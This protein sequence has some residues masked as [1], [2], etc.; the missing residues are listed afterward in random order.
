[1]EA[2]AEEEPEGAGKA[3]GAAGVEG[4]VGAEAGPAPPG[5][6]RGGAEEER[7]EAPVDDGDVGEEGGES[8]DGGEE[9]VAGGGAVE[10]G[11][12]VEGGEVADE[13]VAPAEEDLGGAELFEV[14]GD[15]A[16]DL[17]GGDVCV[18]VERAEAGDGR[19]SRGTGQ[20][21]RAVRLECGED[22]EAE[23]A[24]I[25]VLDGDGQFDVLDAEIDVGEIEGANEEFAAIG[26]FEFIF[27]GCPNVARAA[28]NNSKNVLILMVEI[29]RCRVA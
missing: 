8:G 19:G 14:W 2:D 17:A 18:R 12:D 26:D 13:P 9:A 25:R 16:E 4:G 10:D 1:L 15:G 7:V 5:E 28:S 29:L 27:A 6:E 21:R 11:D 3:D 23:I 20:R 22:G 24:A